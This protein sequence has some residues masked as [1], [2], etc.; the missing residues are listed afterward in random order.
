MAGG[1]EIRRM[2]PRASPPTED[3]HVKADIWAPGLHHLGNLWRTCA[4]SKAA[5]PWR[6]S[7]TRS[8]GRLGWHHRWSLRLPLEPLQPPVA[9][10]T[11]H[12]FLSI[13]RHLPANCVHPLKQT[14]GFPQN[15]WF[16]SMF[17]LFQV[18]IF[19]WTMFVFRGV[20]N[21]CFWFP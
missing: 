20:F 21:G 13:S 15:W 14:A 12:C 2:R 19:R 11:E 9:P 7:T 17:L 8:L 6:T 1:C 16:G 3:I 18:G 10:A 5:S 4:H